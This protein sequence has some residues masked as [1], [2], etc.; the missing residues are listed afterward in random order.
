MQSPVL[1]RKFTG[2]DQSTPDQSTPDQSTGC[3]DSVDHILSRG[4]TSPID[5]FTPYQACIQLGV[6]PADLLDLVN[7]G[8]LPAYDFG[9]AIRF[10]VSEVESLDTSEFQQA[11]TSSGMRRYAEA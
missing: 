6:T 4:D 5:M 9:A 2:A 7:D 1:A 11:S 10:R 3:P 8:S